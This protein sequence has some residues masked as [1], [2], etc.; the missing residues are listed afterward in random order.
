MI[1]LFRALRTRGGCAG[2][3]GG[4]PAVVGSRGRSF[5]SAAVL[6]FVMLYTVYSNRSKHCDDTVRAA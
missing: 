5:L 6:C 4:A 2:R 3:G 1:E